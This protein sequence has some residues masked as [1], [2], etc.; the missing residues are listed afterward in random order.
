VPLLQS[1]F[2]SRSA[3]GFAARDSEGRPSRAL[4]QSH[5]CNQF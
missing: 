2:V 4:T 3:T 5:L 1:T